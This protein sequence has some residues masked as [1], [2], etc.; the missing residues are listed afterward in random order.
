MGGYTATMQQLDQRYLD[1]L[2]THDLGEL[3]A[4]FQAGMKP[5]HVCRGRTLF[6]WMTEMYT[7]SPRFGDCVR[8]LLDQ[9]VSDGDRA[10]ELVLLDDGAALA[11]A[12]EEEPTL[13]QHRVDLRCAFTP[14]YGATLLHVAAEFVCE[15]S[16]RTLLAA[17]ADVD[18]PAGTD[19]HG[20]NGHTPLFHTVS[21]NANYAR[22]VM[23]LLLEA[24]ADPQFRVAGVTWGHDMDW[25]TTLLDL[26]PISY[27]QFGMLPQFH[28][29]EEDTKSN[30]LRLL[31]AA[32]RAGPELRNVP[33]RYLQS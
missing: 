8:L 27:T 17:G 12:L 23:E 7:R 9:G 1:A 3:E 5:D 32:G 22:P 24:G 14:L 30:V 33:N 28:R 29:R 6:A 20:L 26:T 19:A 15:A 4:V 25:E 10:L 11:R 2:E 18:A 13:L 21:S 16:V 31:A